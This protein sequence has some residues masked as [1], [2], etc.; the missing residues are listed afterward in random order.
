MRFIVSLTI[1]YDEA[2]NDANLPK[3][4]IAKRLYD[5]MDKRVGLGDFLFDDEPVVD[6]YEVSVDYK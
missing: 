2:T 4:E 5:F 1:D 3:H 6:N